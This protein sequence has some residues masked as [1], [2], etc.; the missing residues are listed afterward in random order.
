MDLPIN[1]IPAAGNNIDVRI[2]AVV[3]QLLMLSWIIIMYEQPLESYISQR[4]TFCDL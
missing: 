3:L 4:N 2:N 1:H